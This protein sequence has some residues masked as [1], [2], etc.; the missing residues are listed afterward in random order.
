MLNGTRTLLTQIDHVRTRLLSSSIIASL[1]SSNLKLSQAGSQFVLH[2]QLKCRREYVG[3]RQPRPEDFVI[4]RL[5]LLHQG[6][7]Y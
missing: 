2:E 7:M 6:R 1:I 4:R 5:R 3:F